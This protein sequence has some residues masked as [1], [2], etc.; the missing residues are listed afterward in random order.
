MKRTLGMKR[1]FLL[2]AA[3]AALTV[4]ASAQEVKTGMVNDGTWRFL[5]EV[6]YSAD[7]AYTVSYAREYRKNL[8]ATD[9]PKPVTVTWTE[10]NAARV[11]VSRSPLFGPPRSRWKRM[12]RKSITSSP[13]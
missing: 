5:E 12:S 13:G 10:G 7:T 6:D 1:R 3:L 9:R 4:C 8:H 11:L 2:L